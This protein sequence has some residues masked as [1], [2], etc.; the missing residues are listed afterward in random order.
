MTDRRRTVS[1]LGLDV[2]AIIRLDP[3]L[4]AD[5]EQRTYN[6]FHVP[7]AIGSPYIPTQKD[8][9]LPF[10]VQSVLGFGGVLSTGDLYV[11]VVFAKLHVPREVAD[12]AKSLAKKVKDAVQPFAETRGF[13]AAA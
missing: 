1:M 11:V 12:R 7:E 6:A 8:F 13:A 2:S 5:L 10:G 4:I 3:G 9:V